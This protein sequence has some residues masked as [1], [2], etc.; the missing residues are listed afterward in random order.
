MRNRFAKEC[1][2]GSTMSTIHKWYDSNFCYHFR[3]L[4]E[5]TFKTVRNSEFLRFLFASKPVTI[6]CDCITSCIQG[7]E[8]AMTQPNELTATEAAEAIA[9][10]TMTSIDLVHWCR[11]VWTA[12]TPAR[13][14]S[15]LG[16]IS[17]TK[18]LWRSPC[19]RSRSGSRAITRCAGGDQRHY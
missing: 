10:G 2:K 13:P 7:E 18:R 17:M 19:L 11:P 5:L 1:L 14:T 6:Q 4:F 9:S 8:D 16:H 3:A 15:A 12:S